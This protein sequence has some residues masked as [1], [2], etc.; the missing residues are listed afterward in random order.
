MPTL[1]D[2]TGCPDIGPAQGRSL[3]TVLGHPAEKSMGTE[4]PFTVCERGHTDRKGRRGPMR[5]GSFAVRTA[6]E[7][8]VRYANGE[9][10][11][12]DLAGD[13]AETRNL[14]ADRAWTDR[15][16]HLRTLLAERLAA[17]GG[18]ELP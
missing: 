3:K 6:S 16:R 7:K 8:Y 13:P 5:D 9:E 12:F 2:L 10:W 17:T 1:L 15:K 18:P 14:A 11:L 4:F